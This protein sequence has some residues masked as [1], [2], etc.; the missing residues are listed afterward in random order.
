MLSTIIIADRAAAAFASAAATA[1]TAVAGGNAAAGNSLGFQEKAGRKTGFFIS[2]GV[3]QSAVDGR[4]EM[5][6]CIRERIVALLL[7]ITRE[8]KSG[9]RE[10]LRHFDLIRHTV[11]IV[12]EKARQ[13]E[14]AI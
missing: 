13:C 3:A 14:Q 7:Q 11:M 8:E 5:G 12:G 1:I 6:A 9:E 2:C 10:A 4:D